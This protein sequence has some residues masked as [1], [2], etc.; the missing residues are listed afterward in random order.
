VVFLWCTVDQGMGEFVN[1]KRL[2][3]KAFFDTALSAG[4]SAVCG[5]PRD[6]GERR[7]AAGGEEWGMRAEGPLWIEHPARRTR[8]YFV[9]GGA[10]ME[11]RAGASK[12]TLSGEV[13]YRLTGA[14]GESLSFGPVVIY[15]SDMT[16][17]LE[18]FSDLRRLRLRPESVEEI[19]PQA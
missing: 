4:G 15:I 11:V 14:D 1:G 7:Y 6:G 5:K 3:L 18:A 19:E 8:L 13:R 9:A 10:P 2:A 17:P 12:K 16:V